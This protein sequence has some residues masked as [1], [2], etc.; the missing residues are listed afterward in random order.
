MCRFQYVCVCVRACASVCEREKER[1]TVSNGAQV[2]ICHQRAASLSLCCQSSSPGDKHS[3]SNTE[4][5]R[6]KADERWLM[7]G[8]REGRREGGEKKWIGRKSAVEKGGKSR[9]KG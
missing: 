8:D 4:S 6:K 3:A 1:D 7:G 5:H 9:T 2:L